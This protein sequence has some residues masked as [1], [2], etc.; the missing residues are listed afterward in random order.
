MAHTPRIENRHTHTQRF[1]KFKTTIEMC[2][3]I[4]FWCRGR[5]LYEIICNCKPT[6][7]ASTKTK[8]PNFSN[9]K[10]SSKQ[11]I[12]K[13]MF[14]FLSSIFF[15]RR[16]HFL[17]LLSSVWQCLV[18]TVYT[19]VTSIKAWNSIHIHSKWC[20]KHTKPATT[21]SAGS[22][23]H[24]SEKLKKKSSVGRSWRGE[25]FSRFGE[26]LSGCLVNALQSSILS[27]FDPSHLINSSVFTVHIFK[28]NC[29][30]QCVFCVFGI[31]WAKPNR[32]HSMCFKRSSRTHFS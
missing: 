31:A 8:R 32:D 18:D 29:R 7:I 21:H 15:S 10:R 23:V 14:F 4:D 26:S 11:N 24:S 2:E 17:D 28:W 13:K 3:A 6:R 5:Y 12:K 19:R 27:T 25:I 30:L 9:H 20:V 16:D 22:S 1:P